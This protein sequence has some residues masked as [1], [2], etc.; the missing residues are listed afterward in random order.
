MST[1]VILL[2][3]IGPVTHRLMSMQQW[4]EASL[5][6]GLALPET[7]VATGNMLAAS[8]LDGAAVA[9]MTDAILR[10]FGLPPG[11]VPVVRSVDALRRV[12]AANPF[13]D[14]AA[15]RPD[16]LAGF[17]AQR[18]ADFSWVGLHGGD[19]RVHVIDDHHLI[20]DY[21]MQISKARLTPAVIERRSG[22]ALTARNWNTIRA[23]VARAEKRTD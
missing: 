6:A 11:V 2:R 23:L 10:G 9:A 22:V 16:A 20:V 1:H 13:A 18:A 19:E 8:D 17:F 15:A 12:L 7:Y 14:A 3:A 4:R 5:E 21:P